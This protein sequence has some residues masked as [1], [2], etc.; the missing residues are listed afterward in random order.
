MTSEMPDGQGNA[1]YWASLS[2][3][4]GRVPYH[5]SIADGQLPDGL[6]LNS[7]QGVISGT[8][9]REGNFR[10][11]LRVEDSGSQGNSALA[12]LTINVV[13]PGSIAP[14]GQNCASAGC[15]GPGIG[16]DS[17]AN[18]P[19]GPNGNMGSYRFRAQKSG[20]VQQLRLYLIPDR[21]GYAAGTAGKL[22]IDIVGDDGTAAHNPGSV[23]LASS[24]LDSPLTAMPSPNFPLIT[25]PDP[26]S[27][28]SGSLHHIVFSNT[29]A[30]PDLNYL[31]INALYL[32]VPTAP[33]QPS[34]NDVDQAVLMRQGNG[35]WRPRSGYTPIMELIYSDGSS[36][37][38]GYMECWVGTQEDVSGD[39]SVRETFKVTG[40]SRNAGMVGIRAARVSGNDALNI[41]LENDDG[42]LIEEGWID[43]NA[44][45]LNNSPTHKWA[46]YVFSSPHVLNPGQSYHLVLQ[47]FASS[48]YKL[49]PV[50]KGVGYGFARSTFFSDGFAQM[51]EGG[52]D[53]VG[54]TQ[55]GVPNRSDGDLQFYF[56]IVH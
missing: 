30:Q 14:A 4:G 15:Y 39:N 24:L 56:G 51:K 44:F 45:P 33:G 55:W 29:D 49:F 8:T 10:F 16:A 7:N 52:S 35:T 31:S 46:T 37:G 3:A 11:T 28:V 48:T 5:W 6:V 26:P 34:F 36:V 41:R 19:I 38:I 54:W 42:S 40:A 47:T 12:A 32:Q 25:F 1:L 22:Q 43:A 18:T 2:A 50:R 27:L 20:Q 21:P 23:V 9:S 17:L 13:P 53:W